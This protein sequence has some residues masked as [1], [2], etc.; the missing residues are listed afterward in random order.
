[1]NIEINN[2]SPQTK[3]KAEIHRG[4]PVTL[5][6]PIEASTAV[7]IP[8]CYLLKNMFSGGLFLTEGGGMCRQRSSDT[9]GSFFL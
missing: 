2:T 1:M 3:Q 7:P 5:S 6:G 8:Y 4:G 9:T